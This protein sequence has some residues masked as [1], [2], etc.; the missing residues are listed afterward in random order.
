M[1]ALSNVLLPFTYLWFCNINHYN[2]IT[3]DPVCWAP[4]THG[5]H[6]RLFWL[7]ISDVVIGLPDAK[8]NPRMNGWITGK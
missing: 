1:S 4:Q 5:L 3:C 6:G 2:S 7:L 8:Q